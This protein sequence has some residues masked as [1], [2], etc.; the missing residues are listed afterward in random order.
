M[1]NA[2][3]NV[4]L[5]SDIEIIMNGQSATIPGAL[6]GRQTNP[7]SA[8]SLVLIGEAYYEQYRIESAG[9]RIATTAVPLPATLLL[10]LPGLG[11]LVVLRRL[12][13]HQEIGTGRN[14]SF[15]VWR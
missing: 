5:S 8:L 2:V 1:F 4:G 7:E 6:L 15:N 3:I 9:V 13:Q 14:H 10:L 12:R 11:V